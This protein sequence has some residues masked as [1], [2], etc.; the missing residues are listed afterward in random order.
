MHQS[1]CIDHRI[2][3]PSQVPIVGVARD[4]IVT[5]W[6]VAAECLFG[7]TASEIVGKPVAILGSCEDR[8]LKVDVIRCVRAGGVVRNIKTVRVAKDGRKIPVLLTVEP[9]KDQGGAVVGMS[10]SIVD[11]SKRRQSQAAVK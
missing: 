6:N 8:H 2:A 10:T 5:S 4:G 7:Y 11:M 9:I 1:T 3:M